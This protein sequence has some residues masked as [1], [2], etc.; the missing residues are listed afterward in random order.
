MLVV[1][2]TTEFVYQRSAADSIGY[3]QHVNSGRNKE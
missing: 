1:Q 3:T 2:D